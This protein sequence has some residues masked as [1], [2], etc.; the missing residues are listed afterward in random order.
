[1]QRKLDPQWDPSIARK[2]CS[3][4][5]PPPVPIPEARGNLWKQVTQLA[6]EGI[7]VLLTTH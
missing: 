3:S 1:M 4:T 5:S 7:T 2:F 6:R